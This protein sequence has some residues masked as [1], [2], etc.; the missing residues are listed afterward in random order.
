MPQPPQNPAVQHCLQ[1]YKTTLAAERLKGASRHHARKRAVNAYR[2]TLPI[3]AGPAR[4]QD[5]KA[6]VIHARDRHLIDR[7]LSNTLL[8]AANLA[9]QNL[10]IRD[11]KHR[12]RP[13]KKASGQLPEK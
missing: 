4:I 13:R 11:P 12:G 2:I 9:L 8:R 6:C 1:A 7:S 3:L 10:K 5:F